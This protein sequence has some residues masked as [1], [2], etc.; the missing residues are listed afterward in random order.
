MVLEN[1]PFLGCYA[2][3]IGNLLPT[4]RGN[5]SVPSSISWI[6]DPWR[7]G[8]WAVPK[9]RWRITITCCVIA[10]KSAVLISFVEETWNLNEIFIW[11]HFLLSALIIVSSLLRFRLPSSSYPLNGLSVL[12]WKLQLCIWSRKIVRANLTFREPCIVIYS[13]NK[14]QRGTLFLKFIW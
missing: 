1:Y 13:Y 9:R 2:A 7:L 12:I 6:L 5:P 8:R 10:Q 4:F 11:R 14:S 3:S